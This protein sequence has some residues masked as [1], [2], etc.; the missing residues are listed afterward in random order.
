MN[1]RGF[2]QALIGSAVL[3]PDRLLWVPG[4][5]LISIPAPQVGYRPLM[6][7]DITKMALAILEKNL[8]FTRNLQLEKPIRLGATLNVRKPAAYRYRTVCQPIR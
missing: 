2:L 6:I 5:K 7:E 4:R 8:V 1:R 3:D